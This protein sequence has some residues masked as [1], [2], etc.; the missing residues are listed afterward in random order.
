MFPACSV[1]KTKRREKVLDL[2]RIVT[3][4]KKERDRISR[5]IV[6][7][8]ESYSPF[9]AKKTKAVATRRPASKGK[10]RGGITPEGR[11]RLSLAMKRRW[12]ERKKMGL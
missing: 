6:A 3:D 5:A 1:F 9:A 2:E 7:L 10:K 8:V 12:A 11:K 4:L